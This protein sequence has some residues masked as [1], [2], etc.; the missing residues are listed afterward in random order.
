MKRREFLVGGLGTALAGSQ[1]GLQGESHSGR[2]QETADTLKISAFQGRC[3]DDF[4]QNLDRVL[5]VMDQRGEAGCDFLCFPEAYLSNYTA[6]LAVPLTDARIQRLIE[7]SGRHDMVTVVGL[8]ELEGGKILNTALVLSEGKLLG[9]YRKTMLTSFD[10]KIYA[11]DFSLPVFKAKGLTFGVI[12]CHDSSFLEPAMTMRCKGARLL[13]SPHY[14]RISADR[15]DEHRKAVRNTHTGLATHLQMVVVRSNVVGWSDRGLGY[16]DTTIFS[17][18]GEVVSA[19]PL[20][21]ETVISAQFERSDFE[22]DEWFSRREIPGEVI[23]QLAQSIR[24]GD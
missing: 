10:K 5:N 7:A 18:L 4:D 22:H 19:A 20:F 12:I 1:A 16:G 13:F 3:T 2:Q 9:K 6:E 8:S 15:M 14:N 11:T 24:S 23:E 21:Q 17:P